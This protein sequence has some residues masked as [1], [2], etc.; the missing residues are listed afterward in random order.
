MERKLKADWDIAGVCVFECVETWE[1][2]VSWKMGKKRTQ[3]GHPWSKMLERECGQETRG[4]QTLLPKWQSSHQLPQVLS[5]HGHNVASYPAPFSLPPIMSCLL[6]PSRSC[7][8]PLGVLA[9]QL[10]PIEL[11]LP[12][13]DTTH[14]S[15]SLGN[16][17]D[18][19]TQGKEMF[20]SGNQRH[21]THW[22]FHSF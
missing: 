7:T 3:K 15:P 14:R 13:S 10:S 12:L 21:K 18:P 16:F 20:L 4:G 6:T 17:T 19:S 22:C 9:I 8:P 1:L 5:Q 2:S 11:W